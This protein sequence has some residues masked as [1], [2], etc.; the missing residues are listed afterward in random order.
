M[1]AMARVADTAAPLVLAKGG[2]PLG[3]TGPGP[4]GPARWQM[5]PEKR[6]RN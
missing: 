4:D 6:N 1:R 5:L 3:V 2:E